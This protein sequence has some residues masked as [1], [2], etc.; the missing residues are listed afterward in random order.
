MSHLCQ[1]TWRIS[2]SKINHHF[3][4]VQP[5]LTTITTITCWKSIIIQNRG[6]KFNRQWL[7]TGFIVEV[8]PNRQYK[9]RIHGSSHITFQN[10][11]FIKKL[12]TP[13][14]TI[15]VSPTNTLTPWSTIP[16]QVDGTTSPTTP[17]PT[18]ESTA[19]P[20]VP[21]SPVAIPAKP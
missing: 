18:N 3:G 11:R 17:L 5:T 13:T 4:S 19:K 2:I 9:I 16:T 6:H 14:P 10:R 1:T 15:Y 8:L 21:Q 20:T 12:S 7:K